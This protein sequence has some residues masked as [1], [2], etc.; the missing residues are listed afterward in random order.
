MSV[1]LQS[2]CGLV[3]HLLAVNSNKLTNAQREQ[4]ITTLAIKKIEWLQYSINDR[5][6]HRIFIC[7]KVIAFLLNWLQNQPVEIFLHFNSLYLS[8][9]EK[10]FTQ[11][12]ATDC[13][14]FKRLF[15]FFSSVLLTGSISIWTEVTTHVP[16]QTST[17]HHWPHRNWQKSERRRWRKPREKQS[18]KQEKKKKRRGNEKKKENGN[19]RERKRLREL[20]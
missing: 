2:C 17:S 14:N 10:G 12:N 11:Q 5:T 13:G 18:R 7:H 20:L 19:G 1:S 15:I 8:R 4:L 9:M 16:E 3:L 6:C